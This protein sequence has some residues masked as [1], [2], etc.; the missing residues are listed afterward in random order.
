MRKNSFTR[1][2]II[3]LVVILLLIWAG[4]AFFHPGD[5]IRGFWR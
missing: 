5:G 2:N 1:F 3:A 4:L